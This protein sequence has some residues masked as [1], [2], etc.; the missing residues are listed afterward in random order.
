MHIQAKT[1]FFASPV[2]VVP[3]NIRKPSPTGNE[4]K[5]V[6]FAARLVHRL[7]NQPKRKVK[8]SDFPKIRQLVI[9]M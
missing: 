9:N 6:G 8:V 3:K 1:P 2:F 4:S 7:G 5:R